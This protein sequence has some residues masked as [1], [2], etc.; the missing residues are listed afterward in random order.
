MESRLI[1][2]DSV[3]KSLRD[4]FASGYF[5]DISLTVATHSI[6][7]NRLLLAASSD[8]FQALL[9]F[10]ESAVFRDKFFL[11]AEYL[12]AR[13]VQHV[14]NYIHSLGLD[15]TS[16]PVEEYADVYAA[17]SFLQIEFIFLG[18]EINVSQ[19]A[20]MVKALLCWV[21]HDQERRMDFFE[22]NFSALLRLSMVSADD[23]RQIVKDPAFSKTDAALRLLMRW[24]FSTYGSPLFSEEQLKDL[25]PHTL[26]LISKSTLNTSVEGDTPH[27]S[28]AG[29]LFLLLNPGSE[30]ARVGTD[31]RI[32][33][34]GGL[35]DESLLRDYTPDHSFRCNTDF[36]AYSSD[37]KK[38]VHCP[39]LPGT[40]RIYHGIAASHTWIYLTG[41]QLEDGT[42]LD[43]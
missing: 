17:S 23:L 26:A 35:E 11:E 6:R 25:P 4:L 36:Y 20:F 18:D 1:H 40:P 2:I 42:I 8:Y 15:Y 12:T 34:V 37:L 19:E 30:S 14:V 27:I 39:P 5:L 7:C 16:I 31:F 9:K 43:R 41:G 22:K 32:Y 3:S 13:G 33:S 38:I 10:D 24:F 29:Q 21:A 28:Q